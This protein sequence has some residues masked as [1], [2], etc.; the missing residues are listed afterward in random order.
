MAMIHHTTALPTFEY[1]EVE[2]FVDFRLKELR[3]VDEPYKRYPFAFLCDDELKAQLRGLRAEFSTPC[4]MP[5]LDGDTIRLLASVS[6]GVDI[7]TGMTYPAL[8]KGGYDMD[9]GVHI[10][11]VSAEWV[12]AL[13]GRDYRA[14]IDVVRNHRLRKFRH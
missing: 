4:Y 6:T 9:A 13:R 8:A 11:D 7:T 1:R 12:E 14:Y 3:P 5:E 10:L 2:Y